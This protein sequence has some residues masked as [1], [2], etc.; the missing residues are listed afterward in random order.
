[1]MCRH[2]YDLGYTPRLMPVPGRRRQKWVGYPIY[3]CVGC[4]KEVVL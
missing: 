4:G 1:M 2:V 3:K